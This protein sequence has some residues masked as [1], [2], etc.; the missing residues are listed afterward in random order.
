MHVLGGAFVP[1]G[2]FNKEIRDACKVGPDRD[3]G[4]R[5]HIANSQFGPA[6]IISL[7]RSPSKRNFTLG[8][9]GDHLVLRL[10][11]SSTS[12]N[13]MDFKLAPIEPGF[14]QHVVV[15]YKPGLLVCYLNGQIA[16]QTSFE[17][18]NLD[19][20]HGSSY[21]LIF[22]NEVGVQPGRIPRWRGYLWQIHRCRGGSEEIH[23]CRGTIAQRLRIDR[24]LSGRK[25]PKLI[26]SPGVLLSE[27]TIAIDQGTSD[28]KS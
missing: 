2:T 24:R 13:G 23:L 22:G 25:Y 5:L 8:Q 15:T 11:T 7:S 20:W 10:Q 16:S 28:S 3:R 27:G 18:G 17:R 21:S 14:P 9:E 12:R 26:P 19:K 4:D 1:D 6:R